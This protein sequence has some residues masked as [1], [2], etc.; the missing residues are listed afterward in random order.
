MK[1]GEGSPTGTSGWRGVDPTQKPRQL[2]DLSSLARSPFCYPDTFSEVLSGRVLRNCRQRPLQNIRVPR[3]FPELLI[4][5]CWAKAWAPGRFFNLPQ[6]GK[7]LGLEPCSSEC[8]L[9]SSP[10]EIP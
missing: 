6:C 10:M 8:G 4:Y 9:R 3:I 1:G 7:Q 2:P 5:L